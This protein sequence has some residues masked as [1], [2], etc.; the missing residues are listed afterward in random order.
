MQHNRFCHQGRADVLVGW[1]IPIS[2]EVH[3]P[4]PLSFAP[5]SS[6]HDIICF[7]TPCRLPVRLMNPYLLVTMHNSHKMETPKC[8]TWV[9]LLG[10]SM[11]TTHLHVYFLNLTIT[12]LNSTY[13]PSSHLLVPHLGPS[14]FL[15]PP[16]HSNATTSISL[17]TQ[18][19]LVE[20]NQWKGFICPLHHPLPHWAV[21]VTSFAS[22]HPVDNQ[23]GWWIHIYL[24]PHATPTR[25]KNSTALTK[26]IGWHILA[27]R[28]E[29]TK[30]GGFSWSSRCN[31][32][33]RGKWQC[34]Q[35]HGVDDMLEK[36]TSEQ[37]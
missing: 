21:D 3:P 15:S 6:Q 35:D 37:S 1:A 2:L 33:K 8:V 25:S 4:T 20:R 31:T 28:R 12:I 27:E 7:C 26:L 19:D 34:K 14:F 18:T 24:W 16:T 10:D 11:V 23:L 30:C 29:I 22:A 32:G 17:P 5:S 9:Y 36:T 13:F